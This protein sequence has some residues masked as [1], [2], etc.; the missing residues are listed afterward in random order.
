MKGGKKKLNLFLTEQLGK[1]LESGRDQPNEVWQERMFPLREVSH[2]RMLS[3]RE[4]DSRLLLLCSWWL[5]ATNYLYCQ[6]L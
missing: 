2:P 1:W 4:G 6:F 5:R 3:K